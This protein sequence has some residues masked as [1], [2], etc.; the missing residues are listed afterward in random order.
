MRADKRRALKRTLTVLR[1]RACTAKQLARHLGC[2]KQAAY[3]YIRDLQAQ[4]EH[5][6][7]EG[8]REGS[9]GPLSVAYCAS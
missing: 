7:Q 5:L 3:D 8:K 9:C 1:R 4:G 6:L 2:S